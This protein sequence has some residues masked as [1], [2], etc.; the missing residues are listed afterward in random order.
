VGGVAGGA[1]EGDVLGHWVPAAHKDLLASGQQRVDAVGHRVH[2]DRC[3]VWQVHSLQQWE[4]HCVFRDGRGVLIMVGVDMRVEGYGCLEE[5]KKIIKVPC[6]Q[7]YEYSI[8]GTTASA[9]PGTA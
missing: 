8:L 1:Q 9:P 6:T 2:R 4:E 5:P 3:R 7:L